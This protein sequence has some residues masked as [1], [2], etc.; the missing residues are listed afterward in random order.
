MFKHVSEASSIKN[1][2]I[3]VF[4]GVGGGTRTQLL[5]RTRRGE[6]RERKMSRHLNVAKSADIHANERFA[7][8]SEDEGRKEGKATSH[9]LRYV[10]R[11]T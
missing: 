5:P 7:I 9:L 2:N 11:R 10:T 4:G 6:T 3:P 8:E 1:C